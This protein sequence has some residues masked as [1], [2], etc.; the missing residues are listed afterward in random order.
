LHF[1]YQVPKEIGKVGTESAKFIEPV[2]DRKDGIM[3]M[4]AKQRSK[5][6]G[7]PAK[8]KRSSSPTPLPSTPESATKTEEHEEKKVK[9]V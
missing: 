2:A 8:R 5:Q 3:A 7:S 1:S 9:L 4:F 6:V